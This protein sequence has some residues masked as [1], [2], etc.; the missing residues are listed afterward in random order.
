MGSSKAC[1]REPCVPVPAKAP[2]LVAGT[3]HIVSADKCRAGWEIS[4]R[5]MSK[6]NLQRCLLY[7]I[8]MGLSNAMRGCRI[9]TYRVK[10]VKSK[11]EK[12]RKPGIH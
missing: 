5:R 6:I 10:S 7:I 3:P 9:L 12:K 11:G 1:V 4:L 2:H 8:G